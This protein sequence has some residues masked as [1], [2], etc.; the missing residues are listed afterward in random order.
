VRKSNRLLLLL[1]LALAAAGCGGG[2]KK[3]PGRDAIAHLVKAA[4]AHDADAIWS[5]VTPATQARLGKARTAA[6]VERELAPFGDGYHLLLSQLVTERYGIVAITTP[7]AVAALPFAKT[8]DGLRAELGTKLHIEPSGPLP[9]V[10]TEHVP[11]QVA[12]ELKGG[13]GGEPTA[14]LYLDGE[15]LYP[16]VYGSA[17]AATVFATLDQ[18]F[19]RGRHTVVAFV[20]APTE[21]AAT[22]WAFTIR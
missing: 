16:K 17:R 15:T 6:L 22:A 5:Q 19:K 4:K 13:S 3:D 7:H 14:V 18:D 21:A 2:G 12:Y 20:A 10:H 1:V 9:K 11:A 8:K